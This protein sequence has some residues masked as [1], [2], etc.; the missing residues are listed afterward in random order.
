MALSAARGRLGRAYKY[1]ELTLTATKIA[2]RGGRA[3]LVGG[4]VRPVTSTSGGLP[5]GIF[6]EDKDATSAAKAVTVEL[7]PE[8]WGEWF[9]NATSTDA[10]VA[11]DV[12]KICYHADDQT[13]GILGGRTPAGRIWKVDSTKGVLVQRLDPVALAG[14]PVVGAMASNDYAPTVVE[15]GAIYDVPTTAAGSTVTLPAAAL[16][17][18]RV[19][20]VADGTKNGHAV[21]YR[22]ATGPTSLTTA[23][24]AA[25]R[26]LVICEKR[27]SKWYANAYVSP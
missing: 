12:G 26:H 10:I 17:G 16:D 5:I 7:E 15:N 27:D 18:T 19:S 8:I 20:F 21:T 25:K 13:V 23:L 6:A 24:T 9:D 14:L 4:E 11:G 3:V 2:Y 1:M 22:D